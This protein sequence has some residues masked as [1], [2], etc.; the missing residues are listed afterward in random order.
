ML[1]KMLW[2]F[3][4]AVDGRYG[5][6]SMVCRVRS[7]ENSGGTPIDDIKS[8]LK[9]WSPVNTIMMPRAPEDHGLGDRALVT[10][11][12]KAEDMPSIEGC[13]TRDKIFG[14]V[15]PVDVQNFLKG[16]AAADR[17][18]DFDRHSVATLLPVRTTN[19]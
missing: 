4:S 14:H 18:I 8:R 6:V 13:E 9:A 11:V 15:E 10:A 19:N 16:A 5:F 1:G 7:P 3:D 2:R 17:M 12:Y